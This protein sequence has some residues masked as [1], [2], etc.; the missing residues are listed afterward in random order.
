MS[1]ITFNYAKYEYAYIY[2]KVYN[3]LWKQ[4][5]IYYIW[6]TIYWCCVLKILNVKHKYLIVISLESLFYNISVKLK[7]A[8]SYGNSNK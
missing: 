3:Y 6:L 4:Q 1:K 5:K 8:I 2:I 7:P